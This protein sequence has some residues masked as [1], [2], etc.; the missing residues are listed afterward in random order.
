[1]LSHQS[2]EREMSPGLGVRQFSAAS[3]NGSLPNTYTTCRT[4]YGCVRKV[5]MRLYERWREVALANADQIALL[6]LA[7]DRRWTFRALATA[8]ETPCTPQRPVAF[9]QGNG[10]EFILAVLQA[11]RNSQPICPLE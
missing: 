11:W 3:G 8:T 10:A 2:S 6:D 1:M 7:K 9:P 4:R 5:A